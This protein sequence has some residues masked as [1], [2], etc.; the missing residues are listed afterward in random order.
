MHAQSCARDRAYARYANIYKDHAAETYARSIEASR[1]GKAGREG[2]R[3][4][5][6]GESTD[7]DRYRGYHLQSDDDAQRNDGDKQPTAGIPEGASA[8]ISSASACDNGG[9]SVCSASTRSWRHSRAGRRIAVAQSA[10]SS[11]GLDKNIEQNSENQSSVG[12]EDEE[13]KVSVPRQLTSLLAR[14]QGSNAGHELAS[15]SAAAAV[16]AAVLEAEDLPSAADT[17]CTGTTFVDVVPFNNI[18]AKY[19]RPSG[20][21]ALSRPYH[22]SAFSDRTM[23]PPIRSI[24]R[25]APATATAGSP[26]AADSTVG[27][28]F[29]VS[30]GAKRMLTAGSTEG[31]LSATTRAFAKF[32]NKKL[33]GK[34]AQTWGGD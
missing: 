16:A 7:A 20:D 9:S 5:V 3:M 30:L 14:R 2:Y 29:G 25:H 11:V 10:S 28:G 22:V 23:A 12:R 19:L 15:A 17:K 24:T 8:P 18:R 13:R 31:T 26:A 1:Q 32:N 21:T 33:T 4:R 27:V 6:V 34:G